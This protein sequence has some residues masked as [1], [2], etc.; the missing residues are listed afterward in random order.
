VIVWEGEVEMR[1]TTGSSVLIR[2]GATA[3]FGYRGVV[4]P[5][6]P[7]QWSDYADLAVALSGALKSAA[8][9]PVEIG[10]RAPSTVEV[11]FQE[12]FSDNRR[13]WPVGTVSGSEGAIRKGLY[14]LKNPTDRTALRFWRGVDLDTGRDFE[15]E[16]AIRLRKWAK[17][18]GHF[19]LWGRSEKGDAYFFGFSGNGYCRVMTERDGKYVDLLAWKKTELVRSGGFNRL[20]VRKQGDS[21]IFYLNDIEVFRSPFTPF[22]GPQLGFVASAEAEIDVDYLKVAYLK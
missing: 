13:K 1:P 12:D 15:I 22:L 4:Q 3:A 18:N 7:V 8:P 5:P 19:L 2:G 11:V 17:K 14:E 10:S 16:S 20:R 21:Y 9:S 6:R